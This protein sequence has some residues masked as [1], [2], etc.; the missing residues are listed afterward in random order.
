M[1]YS[2]RSHW[3]PLVNSIIAEIHHNVAKSSTFARNLLKIASG[4]LTNAPDPRFGSLLGETIP[5]FDSGPNE[6]TKDISVG[7]VVI[8]LISS[9]E[10]G[11]SKFVTG[12]I[13][14]SRRMVKCD[15]DSNLIEFSDL[16]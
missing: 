7:D 13:P 2:A 11:I 8:P 16:Q 14:R 1:I 5:S 9:T 12:R 3:E 4:Y 15:G 6:T 10:S